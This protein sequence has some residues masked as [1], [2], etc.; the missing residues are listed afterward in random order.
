MMGKDISKVSFTKRDFSVFS[1]QLDQQLID[2]KTAIAQPNF[3]DETLKI[4]AELELYLVDDLGVPSLSN[5][6]LLSDIDDAQFQPELNQYNIEL[7]L[8]AYPIKGK[9]F[10]RLRAEILEKSTNLERVAAKHNINIV[11][12]GILPTLRSEHL[13]VENMTDIS[14][15]HCLSDYLYQQR[16]EPFRI[17]INGEEPLSES[18]SGICAEGA[19]T[20][21][22]VHLMTKFADFNNVFNAA[23]L[24]T[25]LVTAISGNSGILLG[26]KLWDETRIALFKQSLDIRAKDPFAWQ[27]PTRVNFGQGWLR[28]NVWELFTE[29]VAVYPPILADIC[30]NDRPNIQDDTTL[31]LPPLHELCLHMGTIWPWNRPVYDHHGNGH[32]RIEFRSIP[33]G[34]TSIDMVANAAFAIGLATGLADNIDDYLAVIPFNFA[35]DNFYRAAQDGLQA[36]IHWPLK[37]QFHPEKVSI[38]EVIEK[39]LPVAKN[40]LYKI[41]VDKEEADYF[42]NIIEQRL[43]KQVTG[44]VWQKQTL[45]VFEKSL[46]KDLA[47]QK[48]V[49]NYI[50]QCRSCQPVAA[51][52]QLWQ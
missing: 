11:P 38:I 45:T 34:P 44:A 33:A 30:A 22:Q 8:N 46:S 47:C 41:G 27:T 9:P 36:K 35:E 25:P 43:A 14:R 48:L 15:Y 7:N 20:S 37:H 18:F 32:M 3:G 51:W 5:Q 40:G 17:N 39:M 23:Q 49:L 12:V 50:K 31:K 1:K 24:T 19:N 10:S 4:G 6:Q 13:T 52:E 29:A 26:H 42:L 16:G 28:K 21:F 2:L